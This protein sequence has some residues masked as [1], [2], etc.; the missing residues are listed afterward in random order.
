MDL[1]RLIKLLMERE[2][3]NNLANIF[4]ELAAQKKLKI[5]LLRSRRSCY[6]YKEKRADYF[7]RWSVKFFQKNRRRKAHTEWSPV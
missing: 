4:A 2:A 3:K 1:R 7:R 5:G 6:F